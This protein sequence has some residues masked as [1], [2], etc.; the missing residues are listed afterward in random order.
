MGISIFKRLAYLGF[1]LACLLAPTVGATEL[2]L[3]PPSFT[4]DSKKVVP[5]DILNHKVQ[6]VFDVENE[7]AKAVAIVD[8]VTAETGHPMFDIR[9]TPK[10]VILNKQPLKLEAV[11]TVDTPDKVTQVVML[12][13]SV[14]AHYRHRMEVHY[15]ILN[16]HLTWSEDGVSIGFFMSDVGADRDFLEQYAPS[17]L[18][19]DSF[20]MQLTL[21]VEGDGAHKLFTNGKLI[22]TGKNYWEIRFPSYFTASSFYLHL[23]Q[24]EMVVAQENYPGI[25]ATIPITVYS[26]TEANTA[27]GMKEAKEVLKELE[28]DYGPFA[29]EKL[30]IYVTTG[31]GGMEYCGATMTSLS[32]LGHEITHSYFAR[33]VMPANGNAGW[34]DEAI[35]SWRDDEYPVALASATPRPPVNLGGFSPYRRTTPYE[36]YDEGATLMSEFDLVFKGLKPVL[37]K[38]FAAHKY[39]VITTPYLGRF[40]TQVTGTNLTQTFDKYV[41]GKTEEEGPNLIVA[42]IIPRTAP[43]IHHPRKYTRAELVEY[44]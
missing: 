8:F 11:K 7:V 4:V 36:A 37:K 13:K 18:E 33:G 6:I 30:V 1:T 26:E 16:E 31:G 40:L 25:S 32:A 12:E 23:T 24:K 35:A 15:D 44:R 34:I 3:A 28:T 27:T 17:N 2:N 29:H 41:Y 42:P 21:K 10:K 43:K 20:P 19:F 5:I 39:Q 38:L 9:S 22:A 14:A